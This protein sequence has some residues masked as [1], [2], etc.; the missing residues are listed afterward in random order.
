MWLRWHGA[1]MGRIRNAYKMLVRKLREKPQA[2]VEDKTKINHRVVKWH[3]VNWIYLIQ[4]WHM[5]WALLNIDTI[6]VNEEDGAC[7]MVEVV[8]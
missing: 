8:K 3:T 2:W 7:E 1:N 6:L 5:Q 4:H